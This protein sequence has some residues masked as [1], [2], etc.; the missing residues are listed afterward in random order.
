MEYWEQAHTSQE[1]FGKPDAFWFRW[2]SEK[3]A[4]LWKT[5]K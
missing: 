5:L 4:Q 2:M 1:M 3:V